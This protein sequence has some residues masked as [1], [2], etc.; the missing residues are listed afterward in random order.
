MKP[1]RLMWDAGIASDF[2]TDLTRVST[3]PEFHGCIPIDSLPPMP[4]LEDRV[5]LDALAEYNAGVT[6]AVEFNRGRGARETRPSR[7]WMNS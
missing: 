2:E 4:P 3:P 7:A 1:I 6:R 5:D